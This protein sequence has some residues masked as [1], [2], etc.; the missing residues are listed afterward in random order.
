MRFVS[1]RHWN[2]EGM[3]EGGKQLIAWVKDFELMISIDGMYYL[4]PR[5]RCFIRE[6]HLKSLLR[7]DVNVLPSTIDSF[8]RGMKEATV[9][10]AK[11]D[12]WRHLIEEVRPT[13]EYLK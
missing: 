2:S 10:M 12:K 3:T 6:N 8:I 4:D 11:D 1:V 5:S 9:L 13:G 7:R